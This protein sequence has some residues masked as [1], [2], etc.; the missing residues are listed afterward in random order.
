LGEFDSERKK[1]RERDGLLSG[2]HTHRERT[3]ETELSVVS[4]VLFSSEA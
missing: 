2:T 4:V 3:R 1:T